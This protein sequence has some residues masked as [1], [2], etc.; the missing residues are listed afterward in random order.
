[1]I[2]VNISYAG[3][4]K[5][6]REHTYYYQVQTQLNVC[7]LEY[8]DFVVWSE[9]GVAIERIKEIESFMKAQQTMYNIFSFMVLYQRLLGSGTPESVANK[10]GVLKPPRPLEQKNATDNKEDPTNSWCYC[11]EPGYG[12]MIMCDHKDCTIQW[13]HFDCLRIRRPPK[14]KWY[15][16]YHAVNY[17]NLKR[18]RSRL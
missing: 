5:L 7:G 11:G 1:M 12:D 10:D 9:G 6:Q 2:V 15:S 14:N 13:F 3:L 8:G 18:V 17:L 4:H 16:P